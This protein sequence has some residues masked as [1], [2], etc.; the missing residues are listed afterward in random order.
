MEIWQIW[1][2]AGI[3]LLIIEMFTPVMF[4]LCLAVAAFV[5]AIVAAI[6]FSVMFHSIAFAVA[7]ILLILF[8][9]P[10]L[11]S[12]F[13]NNDKQTGIEAKY[14]GKNATVIAPVTKSSGRIAIYGE[15]WDARTDYD[16]TIEPDSQVKIISNDSIVMKVEPLKDIKENNNE[17]N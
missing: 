9:R 12:K 1:C 17:C 5:T 4:F 6:G 14:I 15:E 13:N 10:Y 2:I 8:I 7:T 16:C 11:L 3:V